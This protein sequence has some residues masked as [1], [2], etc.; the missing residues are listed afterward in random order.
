MNEIKN[1]MPNLAVSSGI[2]SSYDYEEL[3]MIK[4]NSIQ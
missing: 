4:A 2:A 1:N 3:I